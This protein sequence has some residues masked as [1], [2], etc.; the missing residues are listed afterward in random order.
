M[1]SLHIGLVADSRD[2]IAEWRRQTEVSKAPIS[3]IREKVASVYRWP[4]IVTAK[5]R[6]RGLAAPTAN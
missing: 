1:I 4:A 5:T 3:R 2:L 6:R